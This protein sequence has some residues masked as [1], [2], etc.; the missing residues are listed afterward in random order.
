MSDKN[1]Y[2]TEAEALEAMYA[3]PIGAV[4]VCDLTMYT[5]KDDNI[6]ITAEYANDF[7]AEDIIEREGLP[8]ERIDLDPEM[9]AVMEDEAEA[10]ALAAAAK[11]EAHYID[12]F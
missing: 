2:T 1:I 3:M 5:K 10:K 8:I 7:S 12:R 6:W 9:A 11:A 4:V